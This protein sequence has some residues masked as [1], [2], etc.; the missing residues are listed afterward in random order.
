MF[1]ENYIHPGA[2]AALARQMDA[3]REN[4][5]KHGREMDRLKDGMKEDVERGLYDMSFTEKQM[6]GLPTKGF[7]H[8]PNFKSTKKKPIYSKCCKAEATNYRSIMYGK[9][10]PEERYYRCKECW[11]D[12]EIY[13]KK[14][15]NCRS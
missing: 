10:K 11:R 12:C 5:S 15:K 9:G 4:K 8:Q 1:D 7:I 6:R 14:P 2:R 13:K 3:N